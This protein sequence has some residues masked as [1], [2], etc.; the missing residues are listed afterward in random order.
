MNGKE[1]NEK[2]K[3]PPLVISELRNGV[4]SPRSSPTRVDAH[5]DAPRF[6]SPREN[7]RSPVPPITNMNG[8]RSI[9]SSNLSA[10]MLG[11]GK[12]TPKEG[13]EGGRCSNE[14]SPRATLSPRGTQ[15]SP[16]ATA[17][18]PSPRG[19]HTPVAQLV[20]EV[21]SPMLAR[22]REA[23]AAAAQIAREG[24][25]SPTVFVREGAHVHNVKEH[26]RRHSTNFAG[27]EEREDGVARRYSGSELV[28]GSS[29]RSRSSAEVSYG[30]LFL[31]YFISSFIYLLPPPAT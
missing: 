1:S 8:K 24:V 19:S 30:L 2:V 21:H 11:N 13:R 27:R 29:P 22:E 10:E 16:R 28:R 26:L 25:H 14:A 31:F 15:T 12:Y 6:P 4:T 9:S 17:T 3:I 18:S 23:H 7:T 5:M 20:R